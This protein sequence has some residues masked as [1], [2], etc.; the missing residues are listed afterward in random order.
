MRNRPLLWACA[1]VVVASGLIAF[2]V[3]A[4]P[5]GELAGGLHI[6]MGLI[7][8]A[9]L[10]AKHHLDKKAL[11]LSERRQGGRA[12]QQARSCDPQRAA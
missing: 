7:F 2:H 11:A 8:V 3:I 9:L 4:A 12:S 5:R 10:A 1:A 6:G